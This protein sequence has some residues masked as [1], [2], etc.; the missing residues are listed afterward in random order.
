MLSPDFLFRDIHPK[1]IVVVAVSGGGDS[2]ALLL[3]A[4]AWAHKRGHDLHAVTID[5]GLRPEAAAEAAFVAGVCARHDIDHTT[6]GWLGDKPDSGLQEAAREMR[7]VKLEAYA[8]AI[9]GDV[10]LAAHTAD[11]QAET[12]AMRLA[13]STSHEGAVITRGAAGMARRVRLPGGADL[14]RPLI[15]LGRAELRHYLREIGQP[16]IE[17][18]TNEDRSYERVRVRQLLAGDG[19][20]R[21]R[22]LQLAAIAGRWRA[23]LAR[24]AARLLDGAVRQRPG[25]VLELDVAA[26]HKAPSAVVVLALQALVAAAGG[27]RRMPTAQAV[28]PIAQL[29]GKHLRLTVGGALI[30]AD[31][32]KLRFL[33]ERRNLH[34]ER[35]ASGETAHWDGRI[36]IANGS[37]RHFF[38]GPPEPKLSKRNFEGY[39]GVLQQSSFSALASAPVLSDGRRRHFVLEGFYE[40]A[41]FVRPG[42]LPRG[43]HVRRIVPAIRNFCPDTDT[44]LREWADSL[45]S[46]ID[47]RSAPKPGQGADL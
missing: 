23:L 21:R 4:Q 35:L 5:H 34:R 43:V 27:G 9:G 30:Q 10:I 40:E 29:A 47:L 19:E 25:P 32:G 12:V 13:R 33:R 7:Y 36:E 14:Y 39:P 20:R 28:E 6:L 15:G 41:G 2:M 16:W 38:L 46:R 17:D 37:Q 45:D 1:G 42:S 44:P 11:D 22:L 18:P 3:L 24:D 26:A 8:K 31:A